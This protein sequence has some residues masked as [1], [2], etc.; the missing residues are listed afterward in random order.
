MKHDNIFKI[1]PNIVFTVES[2]YEVVNIWDYVFDAL[3]GFLGLFTVL[4]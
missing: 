1:Y 4:V 3:V 2:V